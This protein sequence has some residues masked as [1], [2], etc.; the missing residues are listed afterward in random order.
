MTANQNPQPY[1]I[2]QP[3]QDYNQGK[4]MVAVGNLLVKSGAGSFVGVT[5]NTKVAAGV[6]QVYDGLTAGGTILATIDLSGGSLSLRYG[7]GVAV[8]LFVVMSGA[9][10]DVTIL[11]N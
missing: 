6:L 3:T 10:A 11:F 7:I 1:G 5:I 8:G 4:N 2:S 9:N